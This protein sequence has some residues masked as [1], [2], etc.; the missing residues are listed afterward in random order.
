[1]TKTWFITGASTGF[2]RA[3]AEE[4]KPYQPK[5][6]IGIAVRT[7]AQLPFTYDRW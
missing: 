3:W 1:M 2:G 6:P 4:G 5:G 7:L